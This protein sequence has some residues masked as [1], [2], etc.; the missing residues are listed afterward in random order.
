VRTGLPVTDQHRLVLVV[1]AELPTIQTRRHCQ[2][3]VLNSQQSVH[4]ELGSRSYDILIGTGLLR[5][6]FANL[7][8][9]IGESRLSRDHA[10]VVSDENVARLYLDDVREQFGKC[11]RRVDTIVVPPGEPTKSVKQADAI[12]NQLCQLES[13]RKSTIVA[14]G[15]GVVGD[16][17]GFVAAT[18]ARGINLVQIPTSL[19]A[20]VDSSVGGKV[21]INLPAAKNMV[22]AFWQPVL[23]MIDPAVLKTLP[24]REFR[25]GL[26]EVVK[27][28]VILDADFFDQLEREVAP[29]QQREPAVMAQIIQRCC[30]LKSKIVNEDETEQSGRRAILNYGHTFGHAIESTFGYGTFTHGEAISIG[31]NCAARLALQA[32]MAPRELLERQTALL[33]KFGLPVDCPRDEHPQLIEAMKRDKKVAGGVLHLVLPTRIGHV[34]VVPSPGDQQVLNSLVGE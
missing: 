9:Q 5:Q 14:L 23:V 21:G 26:A 33:T 28:G 17:A 34:D 4:V 2:G 8:Q 7:Q 32:G 3:S 30:E 10:V 6:L 19:L 13:D 11:F 20:Q 12:W 25:S 15:G 22:G 24:E 29:I 16:L 1:L 27:Y 31:M 18:F